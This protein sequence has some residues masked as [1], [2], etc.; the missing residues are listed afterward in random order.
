MTARVALVA[1]A[2]ACK[3]ST[4]TP[5]APPPPA[6]AAHTAPTK[7][8]VPRFAPYPLTA[9]QLTVGTPRTLVVLGVSEGTDVDD[10]AFRIVV[11][12]FAGLRMPVNEWWLACQ[13]LA[14]DAVGRSGDRWA[15][16]LSFANREEADSFV[17]GKG[18]S[19]LAIVD[20]TVQ[21]CTH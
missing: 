21:D 19:P 12:T 8:E 20:D 13:P 14:M 16:S 6:P 11:N 15:V 17:G 4:P 1:L 10:P 7:V 5:E 18:L 9:D 2:I 3:P